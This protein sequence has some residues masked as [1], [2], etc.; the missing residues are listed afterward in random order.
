MGMKRHSVQFKF[1]IT[2]ICAMLSIAV[3]V[4]GFSIYEIDKY[5]RQQT[6][7]L[8]ER[9]CSS[10][11]SKI[12]DTFG[13]MEK[14]V[15]IMESY[16]LSLFESVE[17]IED[18]ASQNTVV[19]YAS[20]MFADVA[21]NTNGAIA[22][23]LRLNPDISSYTAGIFYSKM[24]DSD[25]YIKL[26]PTDISLYDKEDT[27]HVGW[28]WQ[29]YEAGEPMW[30]RPYY[31]LNNNVFMISYV[32]PLYCNDQFVGVVGMDFDYTVLTE[33]IHEIKIYDNGFA[34]LELDGTPINDSV[35]S[36][37]GSI[38]DYDPTKYLEVS[39][40]LSNGMTLVISAS[41][42]DISQISYT[43]AYRIF[44][45]VLLLTLVFSVIVSFMVKRLVMP[46]KKLTEASVKLASGDYDVE[47]EHSDTYEI[48]MLSTAFENMTMNL[49]EHT[50]LQ[51]KLAYFDSM[52]GLRNTTAYKEWLIDYDKNIFDERNAFG[53]VVLDI[54]Y[55]KETNDSYGHHIGNELIITVARLISDTFKRSPVFRVGGDEFVVILQGRDLEEIDIL[56]SE[57]DTE[58]ANATIEAATASLPVSVA[59]G[60]AE[61]DPARDGRFEDVFDRADNRMYKNKKEM[62]QQK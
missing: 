23:Y 38:S 14:S 30:M 8:L 28:F 53:V 9:T 58:F 31:N 34:H 37:G 44:L 39:E 21:K 40:E 33:R 25:E 24:A 45:S 26:A 56:F 54:N 18:T 49:R 4:G 16:T 46:L 47:I 27:E 48:K 6:G 59:R 51:H 42:E 11:T 5:I 10:E 17:D 2:I 36:P 60:F 52:T 15:R 55:L 20:E 32:V 50:K 41:H 7:S 62:K 61:F 12:N 3:F 19:K 22:Y 29:P 35:S 13:D 43:I 1:L 57:L